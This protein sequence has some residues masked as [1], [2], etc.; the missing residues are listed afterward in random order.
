MHNTEFSIETVLKCAASWAAWFVLTTRCHGVTNYLQNFPCPSQELWAQWAITPGYL[1]STS[2]PFGFLPILDWSYK[3][4]YTL[5]ALSLVS[6]STG[7]TVCIGMAFPLHVVVKLPML[8]HR[9]DWAAVCSPLLRCWGRV[10]V[11]NT[12]LLWVP[13]QWTFTCSS[14]CESVSKSPGVT[15]QDRSWHFEEPPNCF[16]QQLPHL[17]SHQW[18]T[19]APISA[20][21]L[22]SF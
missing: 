3:W 8:L 14:L 1:S 4:N 21:V 18:H 9:V 6:W 13:L 19:R 15:S 17:H 5:L 16:P 12:W 2:C 7:A 10:F 22:L 20:L 11:L